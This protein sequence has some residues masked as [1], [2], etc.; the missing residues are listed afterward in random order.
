MLFAI[1]RVA[2]E[3]AQRPGRLPRRVRPDG[4]PLPVW[5]SIFTV[6]YYFHGELDDPPV[7]ELPAERVF[8]KRWRIAKGCNNLECA[9]DQ[10]VGCPQ[11]TPGASGARARVKSAWRRSPD[12]VNVADAGVVPRGYVTAV[13]G[14]CARVEVDGDDFPAQSG[15]GS[16]DAARAAEE[17]KDPWHLS[18]ACDLL[19]GPIRALR[20]RRVLQLV[21]LDRLHEQRQ[22]L[23][24]ASERPSRYARE[25]APL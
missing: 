17:L 18:F 11:I 4:G 3:P 20:Q 15:K 1:A 25:L 8:Q 13:G 5:H 10:V 24:Q 16:A 7:F 21:L 23:A 14:V 9:S 12:H 2:V 22:C 6:V 19:L